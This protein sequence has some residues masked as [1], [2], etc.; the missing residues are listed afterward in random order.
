MS[1]D[2]EWLPNSDP[3][4]I[5]HDMTQAAKPPPA[6]K[7]TRS[8]LGRRPG[9][10]IH[11]S[12]KY[13]KVGADQT[14]VAAE[15][16]ASDPSNQPA[17]V[18]NPT[19]KLGKPALASTKQTLNLNRFLEAVNN[20]LSV[21][22]N[23]ENYTPSRGALVHVCDLGPYEERNFQLVNTP[24]LYTIRRSTG[25]VKVWRILIK[26]KSN[27]RSP[28]LQPFA[29]LQQ[30][31]TA[32]DCCIEE[33]ICTNQ[34]D[35][36]RLGT[37]V[38]DI[39]NRVPYDL[40]TEEMW[41]RGA[42]EDISTPL[43]HSSSWRRCSAGSPTLTSDRST[44]CGWTKALEK[45]TI[46][47]GSTS[48]SMKAL[49][50]PN[51]CELQ[52]NFSSEPHTPEDLDVQAIDAFLASN[53]PSGFWYGG[54]REGTSVHTPSSDSAC[55]ALFGYF[56]YATVGQCGT[57]EQIKAVWDDLRNR[58]FRPTARSHRSFMTGS[59]NKASLCSSWMSHDYRHTLDLTEPVYEVLRIQRPG[60][61]ELTRPRRTTLSIQMASGNTTLQAWVYEQ[62]I[63]AL[64]QCRG[65]LN[66]IQAMMVAADM[67]DLHL[68]TA[69]DVI[70]NY[71]K[72]LEKNRSATEHII[73]DET[74]HDA[75]N[76]THHIAGATYK[77]MTLVGPN[78]EGLRHPFTPSLD[79]VHL[80]HIENGVVDHHH[81]NNV[82]PTTQC[83]NYMKGIHIHH[84][85]PWLKRVVVIARLIRED[86]LR[87]TSGYPDKYKEEYETFHRAA[88][89]AYL[90]TSFVPYD[91]LADKR[92]RAISGVYDPR[93]LHYRK[94][95]H[96]FTTKASLMKIYPPPSEFNPTT[97]NSVVIAILTKNV[98]DIEASE[99]F[100]PH[101]LEIPRCP[102]GAPWFFREDLMFVD[103]F[104]DDR[105]DHRMD[106]HKDGLKPG[107]QY[108]WE[109]F[110][111]RSYI[112]QYYC[113]KDHETIENPARLLLEAVVQWFETGGKCPI[114]GFR[115]V[116]QVGHPQTWSIGRAQFVKDEHGNKIRDIWPN[117]PMF[118]GCTQHLPTDMN[119]HYDHKKRT[120]VFESWKANS[121][122][123]AYPPRIIPDI[124][125]SVENISD[126][127][128]YYEA[129]KPKREYAKVNFPKS[130][131]IT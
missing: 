18:I 2:D 17:T 94:V 130:H 113:N 58:F 21:M 9:S 78:G 107:W 56:L 76:G 121:L 101:H 117:D 80:L 32:A 120:I 75:D 43:G 11:R 89:N 27:A 73:D 13:I 93:N 122:R 96:T 129:R 37:I 35:A 64:A 30:A 100:N 119:K 66:A 49:K 19:V 62:G 99:K 65:L 70:P 79:A 60:Y 118:S 106:D 115:F 102:N 44:S 25:P 31:G 8:N 12:T 14:R 69:E 67:V 74:W 123:Q 46:P 125:Q 68:V 50:I 5:D 116:Q 83:I 110:R 112:L 124:V 45:D 82:V 84:I 95:E 103:D 105:E 77:N 22:P 24:Q 7:M 4:D 126:K 42:Q 91:Y 36:T 97:W 15:L 3:M 52:P 88:D 54:L 131:R 10:P 38:C 109:E 29:S 6:P 53:L 86:D 104:E 85:L 55:A 92:H 98:D 61:A 90:I 59:F 34:E 63:R 40:P 71:C 47:M 39:M 108:L 128:E 1:S 20:G 23:S 87:P 127:T 111:A 51:L 33:K 81:P 28:V 41:Y 16:G 26:D 72:C 48:S 57:E 114:F